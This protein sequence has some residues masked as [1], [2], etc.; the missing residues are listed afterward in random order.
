[1]HRF[2]PLLTTRRML[3]PDMPI[4]AMPDEIGPMFKPGSYVATFPGLYDSMPEGD[5]WK[6]KVHVWT[7]EALLPM[8]CF[9]DGLPKHTKFPGFVPDNERYIC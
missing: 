1:M 6:A 7:S 8:D 9:K 3:I 4:P 5:A 2:V